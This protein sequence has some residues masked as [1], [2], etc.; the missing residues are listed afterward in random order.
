MMI[1]PDRNPFMFVGLIGLGGGGIRQ[2]SVLIDVT[3]MYV[4]F[5][6]RKK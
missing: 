6:V 3:V 1:I 5:F 4:I 2:E